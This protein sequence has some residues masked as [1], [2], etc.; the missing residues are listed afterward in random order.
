MGRNLGS[1]QADR[2][3]RRLAEL[4]GKSTTDVVIEALREKLERE[5]GR[6]TKG[7]SEELLAIGRRCAALPDLETRNQER[8][9]DFD[10]N[11]IPQ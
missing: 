5:E 8:I 3:A 7:L 1:R 11:G 10:E 4:M 2:L 6:G 9:I